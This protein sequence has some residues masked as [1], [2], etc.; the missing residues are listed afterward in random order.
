YP[1]YAHFP[2]HE[3]WWYEM[4]Q[5]YTRSQGL[6][7]CPAMPSSQ[8]GGPISYGVN[9]LHVIMYG[10]GWSWTEK[11]EMQGPARVASLARPAETIMIADSQAE[12]GWAQG[13][14]W[15]ALYC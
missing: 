3:P 1:L 13:Q 14:G 11:P 12:S 10:P 15:P 5:P 7:T 9:Y 6:F 4:I 8:S 2:N